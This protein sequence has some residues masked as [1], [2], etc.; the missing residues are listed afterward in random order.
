MNN[1]PMVKIQGVHHTT[2][3]FEKEYKIGFLYIYTFPFL[4]LYLDLWGGFLLKHT[5]LISDSGVS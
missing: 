5:N 4:Y 3:V 1:H 2:Y